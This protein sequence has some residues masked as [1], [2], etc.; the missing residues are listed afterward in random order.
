MERMKPAAPAITRKTVK[1]RRPSKAAAK[2]K[3]S[4]RK[5]VKKAAKKTVKKARKK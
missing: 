4:A 3:V 2:T 5:T 1:K